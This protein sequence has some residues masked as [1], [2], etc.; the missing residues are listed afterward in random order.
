MSSDGGDLCLDTM[1]IFTT[2]IGKLTHNI[3]KLIQPLTMHTTIKKLTQHGKGPRT[4]YIHKIH[5]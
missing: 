4:L 1:H 2:R 5:Y 3:I